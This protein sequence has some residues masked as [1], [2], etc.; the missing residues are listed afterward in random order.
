MET[1]IISTDDL[2]VIPKIFDGIEGWLWP[3]AGWLTAYLINASKSHY[4]TH[5][6]SVIEFG[7]YKGKFLSLLYYLTRAEDSLVLGVDV[8]RLTTQQEVRQGITSLFEA[9]DTD[10][11]RLLTADT[12]LL[13]PFE[14]LPYNESFKAKFISIDAEHTSEAVFSDLVLSQNLI[15]E[16]GII[17]VDDFTNVHCPG[18]TEGAIKFLV[19]DQ[20][21][22]LVAFASCCNKLFLTTRYYH[23]YFFKLT[24]KFIDDVDFTVSSQRFYTRSHS[25]N[26]QLLCGSPLWCVSHVKG[27]QEPVEQRV[28]QKI[29]YDN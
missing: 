26:S 2:I 15:A 21:K 7:T 10:R 23:E 4:D 28:S 12:K 17:A 3:D 13:T 20:N 22:C 24:R 11:L 1:D 18:V 29:Q 8:F 27:S 14:L 19:S 16:G 6:N 9:T 5:S 25:Q